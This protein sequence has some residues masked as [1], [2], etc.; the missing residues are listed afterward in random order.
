M[1]KTCAQ[2]T[3]T[4]DL[5][6]NKLNIVQHLSLFD[7]SEEFADYIICEKEKELILTEKDELNS[8]II[9]L[10]QVITEY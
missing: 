10:N 5:L 1:Q 9:H 7:I 4:E 2:F 3:S 6:Q 8:H